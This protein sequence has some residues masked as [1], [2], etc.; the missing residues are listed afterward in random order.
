MEQTVLEP[1]ALAEV[2]AA[3]GAVISRRIVAVERGR[4]FVCTDQEYE[5]AQ[6]ERRE[7]ICV[8]FRPECVHLAT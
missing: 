5:A 1:G 3:G 4:V 7:P 6:K 2:V 8:G